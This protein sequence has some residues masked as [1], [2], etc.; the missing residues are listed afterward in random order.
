VFGTETYYID[1]TADLTG[2]WSE[3]AGPLTGTSSSDV[4]ISG[5]AGFYRVRAE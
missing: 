3:V 2:A 4:V 5:S 1:Y